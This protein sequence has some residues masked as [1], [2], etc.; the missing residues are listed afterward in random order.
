[1]QAEDTQKIE[2]L[3]RELEARPAHERSRWI[4]GGV[5]GKTAEGTAFSAEGT[6]S[7][8]ELDGHR[9]YRATALWAGDLVAV[10]AALPFVADAGRATPA[11]GPPPEDIADLLRF[12]MSDVA[13]DLRTRTGQL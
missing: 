3:A 2:L 10:V 1:M 12:S 13:L 5:T 7:L 8:F 4:S 6:L 9:H 11:N